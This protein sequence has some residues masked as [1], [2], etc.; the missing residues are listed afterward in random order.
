MSTT[1]GAVVSQREF[2]P[3]AALGS[4]LFLVGEKVRFLAPDCPIQSPTLASVRSSHHILRSLSATRE[5]YF[6]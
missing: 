1:S 4:A 3:V 5:W 6:L 2:L